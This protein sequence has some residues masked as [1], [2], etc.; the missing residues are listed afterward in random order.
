MLPVLAQRSCAIVKFIS[1][2]SICAATLA[3]CSSSSGPAPSGQ[4]TSQPT[5]ALNQ[6][7]TVTITSPTDGASFNVGDTVPLLG[8]ATDPQDG[9]LSGKSLVWTTASGMSLGTGS[10]L[11]LDSLPTGQYTIILTATDSN[12]AIASASATIRVIKPGAA[13]APRPGELNPYAGRI[14]RLPAKLDDELVLVGRSTAKDQFLLGVL[15]D[16]ISDYDSPSSSPVAPKIIAQRDGTTPIAAAAGRILHSNLEQAAVVTASGNS[17]LSLDVL[18]LD[19]NTSDEIAHYAFAD[20]FP[21]APMGVNVADLD[22]FDNAGGAQA[23]NAPSDHNAVYNDEVALAYPETVGGQHK[24]RVVV[25]SFEGVR[26]PENRTGPVPGPTSEIS[27]VTSEPIFPS[28]R[29]VVLHGDFYGTAPGPHLVVAYLDAQKRIAIDVFKYGHTR[30]DPS[31]P[32]PSTDVRSLTFVQHLVLSAPLS[33]KAAAAGGWD[34]AVGR[35]GQL[36]MSSL[37]GDVVLA[38]W[39]SS[40]KYNEAGWDLEGTN[41]S[42]TPNRIG[43]KQDGNFGSVSDGNGGSISLTILPDSPIR[44]SLG[45]IDDPPP[46]RC[47]A[48][49]LYVLADTNRGP[50]VQ[51]M[52]AFVE[53]PFVGTFR[54]GT[55]SSTPAWPNIATIRGR[56]ETTAPSKTA[57]AA[58]GFVSVRNALI[59]ERGNPAGV[60]TEYATDCPNANTAPY[61]GPMPSFYVAEPATSTL[62]AVTTL[63][64]GPGGTAVA[65]P[66][67]PSIDTRPILLAADADGDAAY[68]YNEDCIDNETDTD[69]EGSTDSDTSNCRRIFL[70]DAD[71]HYAIKN[72]QTS[73][74]VL[75]APP[76]HVDYLRELGGIVNVSMQPDYFA[77]FAQT[78][79]TS[80]S[81]TRKTKTDWTIGTRVDLGLGPPKPPDKF[82]SLFDLSLDAE[83][84][85]VDQNFHSSQV[86]VSLTQST[87]AVDDDV[88]WSKVQTTDFW[89]FP[90]EGGKPEGDASAAS[91]FPNKAY[92][93]IAIPD[94]PETMIG[95]GAL[96]DKYQPTHQ[97]GNILT[98][99]TIS[100]SVSDIGTLFNFL[101]SYVPTDSAGTRQCAPVS[102]TDPYGCLID[103]ANGVL[104]R[105][106]QVFATDN[107]V[108]GQFQSLTNPIDVANIL[109]VGGITY[110]ADL[111]FNTNVRQGQTVTNQDTLKGEANADVPLIVPVD[112]VPMQV[113]QLKAQLRASASF[114]NATISENSLGAQTEIALHVPADIPVERSYSIRPSFGFTPGGS[115]NVSYQVGT[116]GPAATFWQQHYSRPDPALNMPHRIVDT[117]DG[118]KL[119]TDFSHDEIKGMFFRDGSNVDPA[120]PGANV[121]PVLD[122][123]PHAGDPVQ[124][125]VRVYNL[126]VA[127]PVSNL[128]VQFSAQAYKNGAP[129]GDPIVLGETTI[130]YLPYRGEFPSDPNGHIVSAYYLWDTTGFGPPAGS[131]LATY[132]I[133]VTLDP[134]DDI[135]NE[136]HELYDRYHDPLL[137]PTG[138]PVDPDLEKGQNNRGWSMIRIAPSLNTSSTSQKSTQSVA[139]VEKSSFGAASDKVTLNFVDISTGQAT[140]LV[141]GRERAPID[142]RLRLLSSQMQRK[143]GL[144]QVF[145]GNPKAGGRMILS[146]TVQG[147]SGGGTG[148][149]ETFTW[150]PLIRGSHVLYATYLGADGQQA[151]QTIAATIE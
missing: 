37:S 31:N 115:L 53:D 58:G 114:E 90:A 61:L 30:P 75:D 98:Y 124:L 49:G 144:L 71:L 93:E 135:P 125:Q 17:Q 133:Y 20:S 48:I 13:P 8:A 94:K 95:P 35:P 9:Q 22:A 92:M 21:D 52:S 149:F 6:P 151:T 45:R 23:L 101:G 108:G 33:D 91:G 120:H 138:K 87:G 3:G 72:V 46:D 119:G 51:S 127:T 140:G 143:Y 83:H 27:A 112:D 14:K 121:G 28:S 24:A 2:F 29:L 141:H 32:N 109:Q 57:L 146:R 16:P 139:S 85:S 117:P 78:N 118:Y 99:P 65:S 130:G 43:Y 36:G 88:V 100:G 89:R 129:V 79:T 96:D 104:Q 77:E 15:D 132:L 105:V 62:Y 107:F 40:G 5:A 4:L 55:L 18:G 73:S 82:N 69:T 63:L 50:V 110:S 116:D 131:S 147:L 123:A 84:E 34:V 81:I 142:L 1:V 64:D 128:A 47:E 76:K 26:F 54:F 44:I 74:V 102:A 70:G 25:L 113:G 59:D 38:V 136:T 148:V 134:R 150:R 111:Q 126:S 106:A 80:G 122:A 41:G 10:S 12:G 68:Y 97:V 56:A 103:N 11:Q 137:G 86:T 42:G 7:P 60:G 67:D 145:D 66:M 19:G 39:Q